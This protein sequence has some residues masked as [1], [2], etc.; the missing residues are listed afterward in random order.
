MTF[1]AVTI[2]NNNAI[3]MTKLLR[4][5][6]L[7]EMVFG[8][9][10]TNSADSGNSIDTA[11]SSLVDGIAFVRLTHSESLFLTGVQYLFM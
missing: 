10:G 5:Q 9:S 6:E 11:I 4:N 8:T 1:P 3:M 2:C 7:L